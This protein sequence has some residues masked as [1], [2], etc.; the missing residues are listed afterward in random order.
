MTRQKRSHCE[1]STKVLWRTTWQSKILL[2]LVCAGLMFQATASAECVS[3]IAGGAYFHSI[4]LKSD[5]TVW[6][7]GDNKY[8]ALGDGTT[9]NRY[10]PVQV[11][12]SAGKNDVSVFSFICLNSL[13]HGRINVKK[14]VC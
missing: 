4:A 9:T 10:T 1:E 14:I 8:G 7:W 13:Q 2:V 5:G 11:N 12:F 6:G 3:A